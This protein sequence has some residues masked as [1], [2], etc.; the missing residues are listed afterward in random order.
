MNEMRLHHV[1]VL[2]RGVDAS[3]CHY[4]RTMGYEVRSEVIHD[5]VQTAYVQFLSLPGAAT[6]L[7]MV[8][9][10]GPGSRLSNQLKVG[11]GLHHLCFAVGNI[12]ATLTD[13][14]RNRSVIIAAPVP[15]V[16]FR[17]NRIAW[18]MNRD[19]LLIE[20]VEGFPAKNLEFRH[21]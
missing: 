3:R 5:P 14:R 16:A 8:S 19:Q 10:D 21:D 6:Y 12:E 20:L 11:P 2:V 15:A 17:G 7:E 9:P 1:G 18:L 4:V 13:F